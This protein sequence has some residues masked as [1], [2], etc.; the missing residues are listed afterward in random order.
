MAAADRSKRAFDVVVSALAL[1]VLSP[2]MAA[3][4]I[5]IRQRMGS[6]VLFTQQRPGLHGKLFTLYK[7]RT[8][9][10]AFDSAGEPLP[11]PERLTP[12]GRA[13]RSTS[14]DEL[15][16]LWNIL[17]GDMSIVGPRPLL[18]QYLN[19]YTP[20]QARRHEVRPGLTG[21]AQVSGRNALDWPSKL[22]LDVEYVDAQNLALDLRII[23]RTL[24]GVLRRQGIATEGT[25]TAP[26]FMG[27]GK[28]EASP[29]ADE[30]DQQGA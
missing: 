15:P 19:R 5:L 25:A 16:E 14:L 24:I 10:D 1:V 13:L 21:L 9:R 18:P 30:Q 11:D 28:A 8:M 29:T 26:E 2:L 23:A 17:R 22:A 3:L 27:E 6:P 7:F 20:E 12:F 4:A